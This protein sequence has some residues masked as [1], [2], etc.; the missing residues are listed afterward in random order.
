M[1]KIIKKAAGFILAAA[2]IAVGVITGN[3]YLIQLGI[4]MAITQVVGL[5]RKNPGEHGFGDNLKLRKDPVAPRQIV[6]GKAA[7]AGVILYQEGFGANNE[8]L[9]TIIALAGHEIEGIAKF[10]WGEDEI[11]FSG[12]N[13]VGDLHDHMFLYE[14]LGGENQAA[15]TEL[16]SLSS[17]WTT[18]HR[19]RG[20]AYVHLKLIYDPE[21]LPNGFL[22][23]LFIFKGRKLYDPR[24]DS[25]NGGS[26]AHRLDNEATWEWSD[27]PIL[28]IVDYLKG[29]KIN[30]TIIAGMGIS[31]TRI[32]WPNI[33]AE[34]NVCDESVSLKGGGSEKRYTCNGIIRPDLSHRQNLEILSSA[35]AGTVVFQA[36]VWRVFAGAPRAAVKT[37]STDH[38]VGGIALK[39]KKGISER[40]NSVKGIYLDEAT[41]FQRKDYPPQQSNSYITEDNNLELWQDLDLPMTTSGTMAQRIAKITLERAR[42]E[43]QLDLTFFPIALQDQAMD[44][45]TFSHEPFNISNQK[46][47]VADWSLKFEKDTTGNFGFLI[48]EVLIEEDDNIYA[49]IPANDELDIP[50][51]DKAPG[52]KKIN[53][54]RSLPP[55]NVAGAIVSVSPNPLSAVDAGASARV[56]V[57]QHDRHYGF[58]TVTYNSG[59][60]TSLSFDTQYYIFA[61]DPGFFGGS[62][63]YLA[64]TNKTDVTDSNSRIYIG[65]IITPSDGGSGTSGTG[66]GGLLGGN[67]V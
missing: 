47:L 31:G 33:I 42:R 56:D 2:T 14:H 49:W 27:N 60:I 43:K 13:A 7:E 63:S 54:Q 62:V 17:K 29:I 44:A 26:G 19:L 22:D 55:V 9:S 18:E 12:N 20:I 45:L 30:G 3:P 11:T 10:K 41:D 35:M 8:T 36:G 32:D 24:K 25:T 67:L 15:D 6:Y 28:C 46:F 34:A 59:S 21:K 1:G 50:A 39:A 52:Q 61:D 57:A 37:R 5:F 40:V 51:T 23:P 66:G 53:D 65:E 64:T 58:G 38:V 4:G 16:V 48:H